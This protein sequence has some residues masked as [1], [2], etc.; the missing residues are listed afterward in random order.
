[1]AKIFTVLVLWTAFGSIFALMLG[2]SRIPFAAAQ[3][4]CF[5]R[6]F[7]RL[8]PTKAFPHLSLLLVGGVAIAGS[9]LPLMTVIDALLVTRILV[10]FIGQIGAVMLL[11]RRAPQMARPYRIWLYPLPCFLALTG[12]LFL[13]ATT[14]NKLK[15][16]GLLCLVLGVGAFLAW[17][18]AAKTWPFQTE[19]KEG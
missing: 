2:Y 7:G 1:V 4:G 18:K 15:G 10:Q 11:R 19:P 14:S 6:A 9:F 16:Y 17:A 3:D 5:F 12:W 8:H 13:F